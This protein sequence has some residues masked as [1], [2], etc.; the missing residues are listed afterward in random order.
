M[1]KITFFKFLLLLCLNII[2]FNA[3]AQKEKPV[4]FGKEVQNINPKTKVIRCVSTEYESFLQDKDSKRASEQ[5]FEEWMAPKTEAIKSRLLAKRGIEG[6][7]AVVTIPVVVHVIYNGQS[8]GS[9]M[10]I[11]DA[12]VLSQISVL[13]QDF[14]KM[15]GTP[16]HN[17]NPIGADI[18]IEFC[19]ARVNPTGGATTGI[20]RV[21]LG[22]STWDENSVET[23]LKPQTQW[24]PTKY[25]NIWVCQFG[26]DL[27]G[28]LGYAQFP[29][30]SG[31]QGLQG[32][33]TA[34]T[35]GVIIDWR[36][37]GSSDY[38]GAGGQYYPDI[39][40]GRTTTHETG[41]FLGLRHIWGDGGSQQFGI[42]NCNAT[43]YCNDTPVAGWENYD[44]AQ[45]Y[46]SCPSSLGNDMT[47]NYMDYSN[48]TCMN[49][50]TVDQK[51]RMMAVM[52]NS[53]RR[54]TLATSTVCNPPLSNPSFELLQGIKLYPNPANDVLN[55]AVSDNQ[56]PDSYTVYNSLGQTIEHVTTISETNL[57]VNTSDYATGIY[58][59][60]F[61]KDNQSKTLQ[62]V[63]N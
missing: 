43:D 26:D 52:Q 1:K 4:V 35:D 31:L 18:E 10:N 51:A 22:I 53:P 60:R 49:I 7:N 37:F 48:D 55:I 46:D 57:K 44:C 11:S 30:N 14:R 38:A 12:R 39:D 47:E 27:D 42:K 54:N 20:D 62:F 6:T 29:S 3:I 17:T 33:F 15:L 36:A 25:F 40:K 21:N 58:M 34:N 32:P 61:T 41:H 23:I 9:G 5:E 8:V 59:I 56:T 13:N 19:M 50:F 45:A 16:G 28:V 24:D 2:S 63:K